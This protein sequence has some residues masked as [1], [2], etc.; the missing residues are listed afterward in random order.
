MK[1]EKWKVGSGLAAR[2]PSTV[3]FVIFHF[4]LQV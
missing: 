1:N 4:S 3:T 2:A